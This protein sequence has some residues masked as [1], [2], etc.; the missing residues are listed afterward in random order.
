MKKILSLS[1]VVF[2]IN[3]IGCT[4]DESVNPG[5]YNTPVISKATDALTYSLAADYYTSNAAYNLS[6]TSDSLAYS[7]T[8]TNYFSGIGSLRIKD[9]IGTIIYVDTLQGNR[10]YSIVEKAQGIPHR[11]EIDFD[12]FTGKLNFALAKSDYHL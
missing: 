3:F 5:F 12:H 11:F 4:D 7:L 6:F 1:L 2:T 10:I 8:I 9:S